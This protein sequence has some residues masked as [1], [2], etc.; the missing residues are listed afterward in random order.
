MRISEQT[1]IIYLHSINW[2]AFIRQI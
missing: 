1:A 2:L